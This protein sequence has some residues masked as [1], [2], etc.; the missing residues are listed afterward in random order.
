MKWDKEVQSACHG[1][2][3][4]RLI[5]SLLYYLKSYGLSPLWVQETSWILTISVKA[6]QNENTIL[7]KMSSRVHGKWFTYFARF[8]IVFQKKSLA[9][10]YI[11]NPIFRLYANLWLKMII[12]KIYMKNINHTHWTFHADTHS[13]SISLQRSI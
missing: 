3:Q 1:I 6:S 12:V 4:G 10:K 5:F 7:Q 2:S 11:C 8:F 9:I 13:D